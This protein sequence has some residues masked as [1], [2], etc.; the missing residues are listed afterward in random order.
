MV[1][2]FSNIDFFEARFLIS[3]VLKGGRVL[4]HFVFLGEAGVLSCYNW[5]LRRILDQGLT[6]GAQ[7]SYGCF[8]W[9][10]RH[11]VEL[12]KFWSAGTKL[13]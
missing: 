8:C 10:F 12:F 1:L 9:L 6:H 13:L 2:T 5:P 7:V 4:Y 3:W 11:N